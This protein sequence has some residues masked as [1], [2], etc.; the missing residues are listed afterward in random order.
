MMG[1]HTGRLDGWELLDPSNGRE[2]RSRGSEEGCEN[3]T[4]VLWCQETTP[5]VLTIRRKTNRAL[6]IQC[7]LVDRG[8]VTASMVSQLFYTFTDW[9]TVSAISCPE[10]SI[11]PLP[12]AWF[13]CCPSCPWCDWSVLTYHYC[14]LW[15]GRAL[16]LSSGSMRD[17][18]QRALRRC[19][20]LSP[21]GD[22]KVIIPFSTAK[23]SPKS[24][25]KDRE[26][27]E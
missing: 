6:K 4:S 11:V 27:A 8:P 1:D 20:S 24:F 23:N 10:W 21:E 5:I 25:C 12:S 14:L 15:S 18:S 9:S 16:N 3:T 17:G 19:H 13:A 2:N 7:S 22:R 26:C